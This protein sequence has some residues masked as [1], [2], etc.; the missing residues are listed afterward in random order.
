MSG[1]GYPW[2]EGDKL[3]AADLNAAIANSAG[4]NTVLKTGDTM[5]GPLQV[6]SG[7]NNNVALRIGDA[8]AGFYRL[9]STL[10]VSVANTPVAG[11][12]A[13]GFFPVQAL[14]MRTQTIGNMGDGT[15]PTDALNMRTGDARYLPLAGGT[16]AGTLDMGAHLIRGLI[17]AP[18][19][20]TDAANK[21]YVDAK[22]WG[23]AA[24]PPA[25]QQVPI[26]FPFSGKP[27][28][29][30]VVNVP[31]P[32][33]VTVPANLSGTVVYCTTKTTANASFNINKILSTGGTATIGTVVITSTSNTS[34]TLSGTGGSLAV[35][36]VLQIF[37]P[38]SQDATLADCGI[39][40]LAARV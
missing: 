23:Y 34:C 4:S 8:T 40:L 35:G 19:L 18:Q 36:D 25:V 37:A 39:T 31:M 1:T 27:G 15:Q 29:S 11:F 32:I 28:A 20:G 22:T 33:G 12:D 5:T 24:L 14:N 9:G 10:L 16:M 26:S 21:A 2:D 6:P 38:V 13:Q 3:Y 17:N 30:A 7:A